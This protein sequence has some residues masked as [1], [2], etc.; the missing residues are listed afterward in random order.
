M[1]DY[2][3]VGAGSAGC[4]L[5]ARLSEDPDVRVCLIEA[6]PTDAHDN[7]RVPIHTGT[8]MRSKYDWDYDTHQEPR[9]GGRRLYLPRGRML[10]GTSSMNGMV[11]MRGNPLDYDGWGMPGWSYAEMLPYFTRVEDNERGASEHHGVGGPLSVSEGRSGNPMSTAF[12]AAAVEAGHPENDDFNGPRQDGFGRYQVT[13]RDG[14]RWS[15]ADAFLRP[16]LG[17]PNLTVETNLQV[18]KVLV[19]GNRAVGVLAGRLDELVEIRADRE[20][21]LSGGAYNSPQLLMLSGIGPADLLTSLG[22][23]VVLDQ[24]EV[25]ANLQDH[26]TANLVFAHSEP[27]SLITADTPENRRLFAEEGQGPLTSNVPETGGFVR[28][29]GDLPAP[30]LQFHVCP[31]MLVDGGLGV[32]T[33]HGLSYGACLLTPESRGTV[34]LA[35]AEPTAKPMIL[36]N[37]YEQ[38]ADLRAMAEGLRIGLDIARQQALELYTESPFDVPDSESE[39]DLRAFLR[40]STQTLFHPAGTCAMG[41][42]VDADLRVIGIDGLRVADGSVMPTVVRGNTNAPIMAIADKAADRILGRP[43]PTPVPLEALPQ[44]AA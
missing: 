5:A 10:G 19:E 20:V 26:P 27:V 42:V 44:G 25:G 33:G 35:T 11:Y 38:E 28:S 29:R 39:A 4:V 21:V 12:L 22:I 30:D 1:Y 31:L 13:Q 37:Y 3:V 8:L 2:V 6:G 14:R 15:S 36:H 32:P 24:P 40:R 7:I 34:R 16:A 23:P 43:G 17:R 41:K 9:L 18:H